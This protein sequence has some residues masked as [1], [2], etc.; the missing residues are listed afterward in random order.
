MPV[1]SDP[2]CACNAKRWRR[3]HGSPGSTQAYNFQRA[4]E[5]T[6]TRL[7]RQLKL[8]CPNSKIEW[9]GSKDARW[10]R[11]TID[12]VTGVVR[13]ADGCVYIHQPPSYPYKYQGDLQFAIRKRGSLQTARNL[14]RQIVDADRIEA[15][16]AR[17][18]AERRAQE[19]ASQ[20]RKKREEEER[21]AKYEASK[22]AYD[23]L[24]N[25]PETGR[26]VGA[27]IYVGE[28]GNWATMTIE[29]NCSSPEQTKKMLDAA[30]EAGLCRRYK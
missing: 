21:K 3:G 12:G 24:L 1:C 19:K 15:D 4:Q 18:V 14:R 28:S 22:A 27:R 10:E 7:T 30:V 16:L 17:E 20:E 23:A 6:R 2:T 8:A 9:G 11:L 5:R 26:T 13:V 29:V 25:N